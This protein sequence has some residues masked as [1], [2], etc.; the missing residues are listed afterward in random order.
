MK[1]GMYRCLNMVL[2]CMSLILAG[3]ISVYGQ[4]SIEQQRSAFDKGNR[5]PK[6]LKEYVEALKVKGEKDE[7]EKVLDCYLMSLPFEQRYTGENVTDFITYVKNWEA[8][9]L[10]D[11]VENWDK[12][13]LDDVQA[14]LI[15]QKIGQVGPT[16]VVTWKAEKHEFSDLKMPDFTLLQ[17]SLSNSTIPVMRTERG[18]IDMWQSYVRNDVAGII[19]DMKVWFSEPIKL[20]GIFD[21][22]MFGDIGSY[23]LEECN[24][25]Q[26]KEVI[27][28]M[29]KALNDYNKNGSLSTVEKLKDDF[30]GKSMMLE[31]GEE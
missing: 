23:L 22:V 19:R 24:L 12:L 31:M 8:K 14:Q 15:V 17:K 13:S 7:L 16:A 3:G 27:S 4:H 10:L 26:C 2:V 9:S 21:W 6:F 20:N 5:D 29:T 18:L 11:V 28:M 30:V 1:E 25:E